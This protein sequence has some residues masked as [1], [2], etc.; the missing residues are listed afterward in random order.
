MANDFRQSKYLNES[1]SKK[2]NWY[3]NRLV[4][5]QFHEYPK[6]KLH[7]LASL[8][9]AIFC[10]VLTMKLLSNHLVLT[11]V[12]IYIGYISLLTFIILKRKIC[13]LR[14]YFLYPKKLV[15]FFKARE[16]EVDLADFDSIAT[17]E[18]K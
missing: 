1:G 5:F 12:P 7:R 17:L 15:K 9:A 18:K 3:I 14:G 6:F 11:L 8:L 13:R 10:Y 2:G 4:Y 16:V